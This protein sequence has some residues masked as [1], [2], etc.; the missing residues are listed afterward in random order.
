MTL[1]KLWQEIVTEESIHIAAYAS[2]LLPCTH[3]QNISLNQLSGCPQSAVI[4]VQGKK[5]T[6]AS[7]KG[8]VSIIHQLMLELFGWPSVQPHLHW[9]ISRQ[10]VLSSLSVTGCF[11]SSTF[12]KSSKQIFAGI[13][14]KNLASVNCCICQD[15]PYST[16]HMYPF[17]MCSRV[18]MHYIAFNR[19]HTWVSIQM[20]ISIHSGICMSF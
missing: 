5:S 2:H 19:M 14:T 13:S 20:Y 8:C 7:S 18:Q 6:V 1:L 10:D 3:K 11:F 4:W 9:I 12:Q 15:I 17:Q 16:L